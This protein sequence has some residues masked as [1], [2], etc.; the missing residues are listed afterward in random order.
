MISSM[1]IEESTDC[2]A[3]GVQF[4]ASNG[5]RLAGPFCGSSEIDVG[6]LGVEL[7]IQFYSDSETTGE[8]FQL[9]IAA[10]RYVNDSSGMPTL[11]YL[12]ISFQ[13]SS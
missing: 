10:C 4:L 2:E 5:T 3:D 1:G 11:L 8:G 13:P 6:W 7:I 9:S 12:L